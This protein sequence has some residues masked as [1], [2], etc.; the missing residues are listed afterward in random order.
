MI[1][2]GSTL[3]DR[4][5][6]LALIGKGGMGRVFLAENI[7]LGN[8]WAIKEIDYTANKGVNLLAEPEMLKKLNHK[9]LPRIIDI[10]KTD[11]F[12]YI[13]EDYFEGISLKEV[14]KARDRC[15]EKNVIN[16][17][18]QLCEI[19]LYLHTLKPN[20]IIYRDMK[21]GNIIVDSGN[22]IKLI[23]FG[24]AREYKEGQ[25][26]DT[27]YIG[28]KGYAAP[29]Q[30]SKSG[31]SDERTDIYGLGVTLH[32][33]ITGKS[34][35][36]P[37]YSLMPVREVNKRLSEGIEKI[38]GKCVQDDPSKRYRNAA[39]LLQDLNNINKL[40][41]EYKRGK[42]AKAILILIILGL[43]TGGAY[44]VSLGLTEFEAE[45]MQASQYYIDQGI[46][47]FEKRNF[48][49]AVIAF[50]K[51]DDYADNKMLHIYLA[52]I[53]LQRNQNQQAIDYI[54]KQI[55]IGAID[56]DEK[57]LHILGSAYF[58]LENNESAVNY[59]EQAVEKRH[60]ADLDISG[61]IEL[62]RDLAVS[63]GRLY[64]FEMAN[65]ILNKLSVVDSDDAHI[66][67][68]IKG[69]LMEKQGDLLKAAE[70]FARAVREA[71]EII[72]YKNSYARL[73]IDINRNEV[74][75]DQDKMD[76]YMQ[77]RLLTSE[78]IRLDNLNVEALQHRGRASYNLAKIGR[79][80][81]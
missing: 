79:A 31:Q 78:T 46:Y 56:F 52:K 43:F 47:Y 13:V 38:I 33:I 12:I 35:D 21:P 48:D 5:K 22:N 20:P 71:P 1:A 51:A 18:K 34:L 70:Y 59:F 60:A 27:A 42:I 68:Y 7:K 73:L 15:T 39:F 3:D 58:N 55:R 6:I 54:Q 67:T 53:K 36:D 72:R 11:R 45:R 80:H 66:I 63:Y 76:N 23:D 57:V 41:S 28:T 17:A 65:E 49:Q 9:S 40:N 61:N 69:E 77:A 44:T 75:S 74:L 8:K 50:Q 29:E 19:L 2:I 64:N 24:I 16:W 25:T 4:Y 14:L 37:P 26:E 32:H 62:Y 81:V 30:L 10:I